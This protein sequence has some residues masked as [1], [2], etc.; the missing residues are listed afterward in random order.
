MAWIQG[1]RLHSIWGSAIT[2]G[3]GQTM[4]FPSILDLNGDGAADILTFTGYASFIAG[5]SSPFTTTTGLP[6][7]GLGGLGLNQRMSIFVDVNG[8]GL[9]DS[10]A[11]DDPKAGLGFTTL[12]LN[13]GFRAD[14]GGFASGVS[15]APQSML[16][17]SWLRRL[18]LEECEQYLPRAVSCPDA[19]N[20][21]PTPTMVVATDP[22]F[23]VAD[24]NGDGRQDVLCFAAQMTKPNNDGVHEAD[25][26]YAANSVTLMLG[27]SST[28]ATEIPVP[29]D[30]NP[31]P[32]VNGSGIAVKAGFPGITGQASFPNADGVAPN[33]FNRIIDVNGDGLPDFLSVQERDSP[34]FLNKIHLYIHEGKKPDLLRSATDGLG[35]TDSVEYDYLGNHDSTTY[36][37][38]S[39][40]S[41][42]YPQYCV[43][44]GVWVVSKVH[45]DTG[46]AVDGTP[47]LDLSFQYEDARSDVQGLGWLGF[48][49][50]SVTNQVTGEH[51]DTFYGDAFKRVTINGASSYPEVFLPTFETELWT[52]NPGTFL[53]RATTDTYNVGA[54]GEVLLTSSATE[55][56]EGPVNSPFLQLPVKT[57]R[58]LFRTSYDARGNPLHETESLE[59]AAIS[60]G[61][62]SQMWQRTTDRTYDNDLTSWLLGLKRT[63]TT[64]LLTFGP[65][66]EDITRSET[67][68]YFPGT[69][70][71]SQE[72]REPNGSN[73]LKLTTTFDRNSRGL[74][75]RVTRADAVGQKRITDI[76]YDPI[77]GHFPDTI[78]EEG[79]TVTQVHEPTFGSIARVEE[80]NGAGTTFV[81]DTFGRRKKVM[82]D[83]AGA[84]TL[85]YSPVFVGTGVFSI[86][87]TTDG[88]PT[89]GATFDRLGRPRVSLMQRLDPSA[90]SAVFTDYDAAGRVARVSRSVDAAP[91]GP[92]E[93]W[94]FT[95]YT[96]DGASRISSVVYPSENF[97][98]NSIPTPGGELI[99]SYDWLSRTDGHY[100]KVGDAAAQ[101]IRTVVVDG[102]GRPSST[103]YV[104]PG[105]GRQ[106]ST[107]F[108]Y[109]AVG[110]VKQVTDAAFN[111]TTTGYDAWGRRGRL[112]DPDTGTMQTTY[113]A[114]D[115]PVQ[116]I[117]PRGTTTHGHD[118]HGRW[119]G[120]NGPDG[121]TTLTWDLAPNG[122]GRPATASS[123][124][125]IETE[126]TY[127]S[128]SRP[129][130][131]IWTVPGD[132]SALVIKQERD[133]FGRLATITYPTSGIYRL[134]ASYGYSPTGY[135]ASVLRIEATGAAAPLWTVDQRAIDGQVQ[136]E[137]YGDGTDAVQTETTRG[138]TFTGKPSSL[139]THVTGASTALQ[140][141]SY[142]YDGLGRLTSRAGD[143]FQYDFFSRLR[144]WNHAS[145]AWTETYDYDDIGNLTHRSGVGS[146][147]M[148]VDE[149]WHFNKTNG[150]GPH[151]VS[152]GPDGSYAYDDIGNQKTAPGRTADFWEFGL[153][154]QVTAN[155][156]ETTFKYA[157]DHSRV[158]KL[159]T[160]GTST[161]SLGG[162]YERRINS[163]QT[164]YTF[165]VPAEG[166][167]VA[168]LTVDTAGHREIQELHGD[169]LGSTVLVTD[170]AGSGSTL[171][172]DPWGKTVTYDSNNHPIGT[173]MSV[174]GLRIGFTGHD[175]DDD[176]G[177]VNMRG[178]LYDPNQ[179]RFISP[180]PFVQDLFDGQTHNRYSYGPERPALNLIDP[181]GFE[182]EGAADSQG[183]ADPRGRPPG[184]PGA[185]KGMTAYCPSCPPPGGKASAQKSSSSAGAF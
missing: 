162:L 171:E 138:Y 63:E 80:P 39:P 101:A 137:V 82:P 176:I 182:G 44:E 37:R 167:V 93:S 113:N 59:Q 118:N 58:T 115:E 21:D 47:T 169:N 79:L 18:N 64:E 136:H 29:T 38:R 90:F 65:Q 123:P 49:H 143:T 31:T 120:D 8:D 144:V 84:T 149:T 134:S 122:L 54:S 6:V 151:A 51:A 22:G 98:A 50:V 158:V 17:A 131:T 7:R 112:V 106:V 60:G 24:F 130:S 119:T 86:N 1:H 46:G 95:N 33:A 141:A 132:T 92:T 147:S 43:N 76:G 172:F 168:Q 27:Q 52:V 165:Y 152:T 166:R 154:K 70:L 126:W 161:V 163:G 104:D 15:V 105:S 35:A 20:L 62:L 110:F 2:A 56:H 103:A 40:G 109:G 157:A 87:I 89:R 178:R 155:G 26:T 185:S 94:Y 121:V 140:N 28:F 3:G 88:A 23:R 67:W 68:D 159:N 150:G 133:E 180:D 175:Q 16:K 19:T 55:E 30:L 91:S 114:F 108:V 179:R 57:R 174:P 129:E 128:V 145:S 100:D 139:L 177:L 153:P 9:P 181:S 160:Q 111:V 83:L 66:G 124:D 36:I 81:Y 102:A 10:V 125:A 75:T 61:A 127:D 45:R 85:A 173:N 53:E 4:S 135:L 146:S 72:V 148:G 170:H 74:V 48:E 25:S 5:G 13:K 96:Y 42:V 34:F 12:F 156:V 183:V 32:S 97:D 99:R 41:C 14:G 78:S 117:T 11:F 71:V 164:T 77:V 69:N 142:G 116:D 73:D 107:S 184:A